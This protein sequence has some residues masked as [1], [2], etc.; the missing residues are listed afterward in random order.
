MAAKTKKKNTRGR[1]RKTGRRSSGRKRSSRVK[2]VAKRRTKGLPFIQTIVIVLAV[3]AVAVGYV[4]QRESI[5][6]KQ[7]VIVKLNRQGTELVG[8]INALE[9]EVA[10]LE[11]PSRIERIA[12]DQL[13]MSAPDSWQ[14]IPVQLGAVPGRNGPRP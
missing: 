13:H 12:V 9:M 6:I 10:R 1:T 7:S 2:S 8:D 14:M 11:A 4:W 3:L 5:K